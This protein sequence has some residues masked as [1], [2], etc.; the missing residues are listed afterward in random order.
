MSFKGFDRSVR[1]G[2]VIVTIALASALLVGLAGLAV[3]LVLAYAVKTFL[4]T[5]TDSAAMGGIRALERGVTYADQ[6]AEIERM[7]NMLF[8]VNFPDG[9]L[10]TGATGK[11]SR[12]VSVAG[13][14]MDPAA[15]SMFERDTTLDPGMRE[16]R[17]AAEARAP[18]FFMR[19]FG[20]DSVMIRSGAHAARRD[21]NVVVVIDRSASLKNA[22]A[23]D[24]VQQAAVAFV[25][26]FDNNRD[27]VG[28]VTFGTGA[29]VDVPLAT[30]FKA[31]DLA[32]NAILAQTVPSSASTNASLGLWLAYSELL[33]V[34]DPNALNTMVFFTDGQ[35]SSFTAQWRTRIT[36]ALSGSPKCNVQ[37]VEAVVGTHQNTAVWNVPVFD[38]MQ[39]FWKPQAG[40]APVRGGAADY[41]H[42]TVAGCW[43]SDN[44]VTNNYA[45][46]SELVI[47]PLFP[48]PSSWTAQEPGG[49][50]KKFCIQ[51]G[52]SGCLGDAGNFTYS[53]NDPLL[54]LSSSVLSEDVFR[55][56]NVHNGAKNLLLNI[57][58]TARQDAGLGGVNIHTIGLGGYGYDADAELMKRIAND[59][60]DS[61]GVSGVA[62]AGE[63]YGS[64]TYAPGAAELDTAFNKVRS[65]VMRLT[66]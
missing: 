15:P 12:Q 49:P 59:P 19:I 29:N 22:G 34:N 41:D 33:K 8:D 7:T 52:A 39:G 35:P 5:A 53:T 24:D 3:D 21:V 18:T 31:G 44:V 26:K 54:Y 36:S 46:E 38:E 30:G 61:Y 51:S 6:E 45:S 13:F 17:V 63:P 66:K 20:M 10:M 40:A 50:A 42:E 58:Q 43:F 48:W 1:R 60:S 25:E 27:R 16:I 14:N 28:V 55:G 4:A 2:Q 23:W 11:L 56:T 62:V 32:K 57:A 65:E 37:N 9:L 64:Y 47:N